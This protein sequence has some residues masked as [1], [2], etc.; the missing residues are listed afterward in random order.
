MRALV[1]TAVLA[2]LA[3]GCGSSSSVAGIKVPK[4]VG[5]EKRAV[6]ELLASKHLRWRYGESGHVQ[7]RAPRPNV[8]SSSD[9]DVILRQA[10]RQG[11]LV[12]RGTVIRLVTNCIV[13]GPCA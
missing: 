11:T 7:F 5:M 10:P 4:L 1:L 8:A 13:H 12:T 6:E 2:V 3:A 9:D